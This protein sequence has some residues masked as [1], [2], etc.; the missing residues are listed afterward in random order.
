MPGSGCPNKSVFWKLKVEWCLAK[1]WQKGGNE[2]LVN[3]DSVRTSEV[4]SC[5]E[6]RLQVKINNS[7][8]FKITIV[9]NLKFHYKELLTVNRRLPI[10]VVQSLQVWKKLHS[11]SA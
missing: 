8:Y 2:R 11:T 5:I 7:T 9:W 10:L 1:D 3:Q 4:F 6:E